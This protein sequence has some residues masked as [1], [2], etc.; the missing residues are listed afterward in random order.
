MTSEGYSAKPV[1]SGWQV[2]IL[3][4]IIFFRW[5]IPLRRSQRNESSS[6]LKNTIVLSDAQNERVR[7]LWSLTVS[8]QNRALL[9][10]IPSIIEQSA[11]SLSRLIGSSITGREE[12]HLFYSSAPLSLEMGGGKFQLFKH[13]RHQK[14]CVMCSLQF[15]LIWLYVLI[16]GGGGGGV[17]LSARS[18]YQRSTVTNLQ[19]TPF[20]TSTPAQSET[21]CWFRPNS[22][23][24]LTWHKSYCKRNSWGIG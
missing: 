22:N 2:S 23:G 6:N 9:Y 11:G 3:L 13:Q 18:P 10:R 1:I 7:G 20:F 12:S 5:T 19:Q 15:N 21:V 14:G 16:R 4:P 17:F 8:Q 24:R